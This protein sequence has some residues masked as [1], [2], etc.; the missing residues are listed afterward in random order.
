MQEASPSQI[1]RSHQKDTY[2]INYLKSSISDIAQSVLGQSSLLR[3]RNEIAIV[4]DLAYFGLTTFSGFQ[5]LGE[6]YVNLLQFDDTKRAIPSA[7]KRLLL[8]LLHCTAPYIVDKFIQRCQKGVERDE[9]NFRPEARE[10]LLKL[11][12]ITRHSVT[13]LH[14]SH[15]ALFYLRG[16]YYHIAK[17][18]TSIKYIRTR[19]IPKSSEIQGSYG[20]KILGYLYLA[21]VSI[22]SMVY[23]YDWYKKRATISS[24]EF[25]PQA[26]SVQL[27]KK[28]SPQTTDKCAL[29]LEYRKDTTAT[30][31]GHLFCWNCITEWCL[32]KPQCP[33]CRTEVTGSRLVFLQNYDTG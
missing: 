14:R 12:E 17:R 26:K 6:E 16:I 15:L 20:Y 22:S 29:C 10:L 3:W 11:L 13:F 28:S 5:T 33:L 23:V 24:A 8:V 32:M 4:A 7:P 21:Q 2:Y 9:L 31:C 27:S 30:P 1:I 19:P 25:H 18:V